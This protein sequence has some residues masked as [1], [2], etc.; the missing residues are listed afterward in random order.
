M[1]TFFMHEKP[2]IICS[3]G[4]EKAHQDQDIP[5]GQ[6]MLLK[7][8][9]LQNLEALLNTL[10]DDS[11]KGYIWETNNPDELWQRAMQHFQHWQAAGGL[12]TNSTGEILLMFRRGKWDLPKG[13]MDQ[14]ET[15]EQTAL[16]EVTE[17]TGL[18]NIRIER[19][20]TD[21]WHVYSPSVYKSRKKKFQNEKDILKQTHWYKMAFTGSE[22][23]VP[24]IEEDI[25]DIQWVRPENIQKYLPY[26]YPNLKIV[27]QSA[28][29]EV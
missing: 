23:T 17:E 11:V 10:K 14:T 9:E 8:P 2:V 22:L 21:T 7:D 6:L 5:G 16:R 26:A 4:T 3:E 1:T 12:I 27:F 28:G 15:P 13:K 29:Y 24:Q 19:K 20:L 18:Q 25:V